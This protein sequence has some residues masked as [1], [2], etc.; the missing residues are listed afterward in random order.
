MPKE[1]GDRTRG[2]NPPIR[3]D[4]PIKRD[5]HEVQLSELHCS[6]PL[7]ASSSSTRTVVEA[8]ASCTAEESFQLDF[9]VHLCAS[10]SA[11]C[12]LQPFDTAIITGSLRDNLRKEV[13]I[14]ALRPLSLLASPD[15][16]PLLLKLCGSDGGH[17][18]S[19]KSG[20]T[21]CQQGG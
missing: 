14:M 21:E 6:L 13:A 4:P 7:Q 18:V 19:G 9:A 10:W 5:S 17:Q 12:L 8:S 3:T 20:V 15:T 16:E 11:L 1:D 2:L